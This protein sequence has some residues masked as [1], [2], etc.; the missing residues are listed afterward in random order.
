MPLFLGIWEMGDERS[1]LS[2]NRQRQ[3]LPVIEKTSA[4]MASEAFRPYRCDTEG[5]WF[6]DDEKNLL[7]LRRLNNHHEQTISSSYGYKRA[8]FSVRKI[9]GGN[10]KPPAIT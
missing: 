3:L 4:Q 10:G 7:D 6:F 2:C 1:Y 8:G 5:S 9:A